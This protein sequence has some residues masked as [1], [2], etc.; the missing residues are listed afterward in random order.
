LINQ[1]N[2]LTESGFAA[3]GV[4]TADNDSTVENEEMNCGGQEA[5]GVTEDLAAQVAKCLINQAN[6]LTESGFAAIGVSTADNDS[7][8]ETIEINCGGQEAEGVTSFADM[9]VDATNITHHCK[10]L[11]QQANLPVFCEVSLSYY[12]RSFISAHETRE[13][14]T[15]MAELQRIGAV[16]PPI[17]Y[18]DTSHEYY[19]QAQRFLAADAQAEATCGDCKTFDLCNSDTA[20]PR[21]ASDAP[22]TRYSPSSKKPY[23]RKLKNAIKEILN[24]ET[25]RNQN[26]VIVAGVFDAGCFSVLKRGNQQE[27]PRQYREKHTRALGRKASG[28][29]T[30]RQES[31]VSADWCLYPDRKALLSAYRAD[32]A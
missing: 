26:K 20:D 16:P 8:V 30:T 7:P 18:W 4:S 29:T 14:K 15:L 17:E 12:A 23:S 13:N 2:E 27:F 3:I 31:H 21:V 24:N 22:C 32:L 1:A 19:D 6:E 28:A 9:F 25:S 11:S 5:E 10:S